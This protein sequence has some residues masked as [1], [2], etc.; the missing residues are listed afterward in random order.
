M[1]KYFLHAVICLLLS[2]PAVL[3]G[4]A[5]KISGYF[6]GDYYYVLKSHNTE[7]EERNGFQ[8]RRVY[9]DYDKNLSDA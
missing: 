4:D 5:G 2:S 1:K 3:W 9:F 8:F 6:F 7:L